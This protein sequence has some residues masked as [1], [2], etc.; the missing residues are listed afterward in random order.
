MRHLRPIARDSQDTSGWPVV[1]TRHVWD[2]AEPRCR[3]P[4][5]HSYAALLFHTGGR[6]RVEQNGE[7]NLG[8]G[9]VL[10]VPAGEPHRM[11]EMRR[12]ESWG[13][14]FCVPCFAADGATSLLAPFERVR[15]GA[16]AV[17]SIPAAR[18]EFLQGLFRELEELGRR[19]RG[20]GELFAAVQRSLLTLILAEVDRAAGPNEARRAGGGVVVDALRFI[21][22]HCLG[23][24]TLKDVAAAVGRTPTYVTAALTQATGRSAGAWI[25]SGRMAEARR[26]LLHSDERV[27]IVAERVGYADA[28]HFIRMFRREHGATPA[29]WRAARA[30]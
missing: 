19:P 21:E 8:E 20:P 6:S 16:S 28:T 29:A 26:L 30:K 15:D 2:E 24:L 1:A 11:L 22:R 14:A 18:H 17:V 13:L 7:W 12:V 5:T 10:L 9:D 4:V 3:T 25:V 23:S 27:E